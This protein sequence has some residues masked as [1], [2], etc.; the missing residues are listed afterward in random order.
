[1]AARSD[2]TGAGLT[3]GQG[4]SRGGCCS[5]REKW[6]VNWQEIRVR[7]DQQGA[8]W[9]G[10]GLPESVP[11][12]SVTTVTTS[13]REYPPEE[14]DRQTGERQTDRLE[15]RGTDSWTDR[16]VYQCAVSSCLSLS[17]GSAARQATSL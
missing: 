15:V 14:T 4:T 7:V 3:G 12:E 1:M 17:T 10:R 13:V 9:R 8:G 2:E 11:L 16:Q 5:D 6:L